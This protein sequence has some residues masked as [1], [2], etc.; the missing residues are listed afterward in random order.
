M[1]AK[2]VGTMDGVVRL[3]LC[4]NTLSDCII[5]AK[6]CQEDGPETTRAFEGIDFRKI[7]SL[8]LLL[9]SSPQL[10]PNL[11]AFSASRE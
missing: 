10:T 2:G 11:I 8:N 3:R 4:I 7:C 5:P 6:G 9:D 1:N